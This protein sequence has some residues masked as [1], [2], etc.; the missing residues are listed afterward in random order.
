MY[1]CKFSQRL[2][3]YIF[4]C[5][6]IGVFLRLA[7]LKKRPSYTEQIERCTKALITDIFLIFLISILDNL[8]HV[9]TLSRSGKK[10]ISL[11]TK[12]LPLY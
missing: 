5:K 1:V 8:I 9:P 7:Y 11:T 2:C 4:Y 10:C 3:N 12:F 6:Y